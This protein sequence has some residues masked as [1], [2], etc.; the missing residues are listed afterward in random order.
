M[1]SRVFKTLSLSI[2][3][4]VSLTPSAFAS[5]CDS[6]NTA[7]DRFLCLRSATHAPVDPNANTV[8]QLTKEIAQLEQEI[9]K[10]EKNKPASDNILT[11]TNSVNSSSSPIKPY[12]PDGYKADPVIITPQQT[13]SHSTTANIP[14]NKEKSS[15]QNGTVW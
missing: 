8:N 2:F 14:S 10:L 9:K 13:P 3:F 11:G 1:T 5:N 4:L 6:S 7:W 15:T 12:K